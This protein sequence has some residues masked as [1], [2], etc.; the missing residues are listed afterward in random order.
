[1]NG[2][3]VLDPAPLAFLSVKA[4][5]LPRRPGVLSQAVFRVV[6]VQQAR[7]GAVIALPHEAPLELR[8]CVCGW[9]GEEERKSLLRFQSRADSLPRQKI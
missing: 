8:V 4:V 7:L 3:H 1:M 6:D 5:P 2:E 9:E